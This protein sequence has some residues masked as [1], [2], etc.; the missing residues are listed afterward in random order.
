QELNKLSNIFTNLKKYLSNNHVFAWGNYNGEETCKYIS[1]LLCDQIR[2]NILGECDEGTFKVLSEFVDQCN[3]YKRSHMC[4]NKVKHINNDNF[5]K[6]KALYVLYDKYYKL[7]IQHKQWDKETYCS[8]MIYLVSLYNKFLN[9]YPSHSLKFN[10]VLRQFKVLMDTIT[11]TGKERCQ[12]VQ[13]PMLNP[14]FFERQE[15]VPQ[16]LPSVRESNQSQGVTLDVP[17]KSKPLDV[18]RLQTSAVGVEVRDNPH[19]AKGPKVSYP[20]TSTGTL[21]LHITGESEH[22]HKTLE[23]SETYTSL[24]TIESYVPQESH[25]P[26][27]SSGSSE[28]LHT[29]ST[30]SPGDENIES[31]NLK[32]SVLRNEDVTLLGK[33]Q[34]T[35][36]GIVSEVEPGPVLGVSGGMGA[37]FLLFKYTPVGTFF[38]GGRV[39]ARRI[40]SGFSGPF[41]GEFPD[42]QDYYGGNIGYGQ[43]NPLAE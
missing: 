32:E 19:N 23:S 2:G 30:H 43:M 9:K 13:F 28:Y 41:L 15:V 6:M 4:K 35:L 3:V 42:V 36:S 38:R 26:G 27:R 11:V 16:V 12:G 18:T 21:D 39:R 5:L 25:R 14:V 31:T 17:G 8:D 10:D 29:N 7:S 37:L 40:P 20:L 24:G 22:P 1:Y 33:I 34:T